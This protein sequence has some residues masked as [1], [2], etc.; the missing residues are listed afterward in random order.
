M[1]TQKVTS[2]PRS[3]KQK[4]VTV[5]HTKAISHGK[6]SRVFQGIQFQLQQLTRGNVILWLHSAC[7]RA[8][9][10]GTEILLLKS[11]LHFR[12]KCL[13]SE[14]IPKMEAQT[15]RVTFVLSSSRSRGIAKPK[16]RVNARCH[17]RRMLLQSKLQQRP[18]QPNNYR[19]NLHLILRLIL[20]ET[21]Q[22]KRRY[23]F[24][25]VQTWSLGF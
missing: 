23:D 22:A 12:G 14:K 5:W 18:P 3:G 16:E 13:T 9:V 10:T 24:F 4:K 21:F 6:S 25:E 11:Q 2:L 1:P 20:Q 7:S 15:I 17:H 19:K 8:S